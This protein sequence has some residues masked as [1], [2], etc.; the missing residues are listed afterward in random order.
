MGDLPPRPRGIPE[1]A[2]V[3][4]LQSKKDQYPVAASYIKST[5]VRLKFELS[6]PPALAASFIFGV[7]SAVVTGR[8]HLWSWPTFAWA[9]VTVL[10]ITYFYREAGWTVEGLNGVRRGVYSTSGG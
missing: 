10:L 2:W 3:R 8:I 7:I 1:A 5:V 6:M 9:G 4:Y